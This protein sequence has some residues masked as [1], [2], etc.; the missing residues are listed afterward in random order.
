LAEAPLDRRKGH[1]L[2]LALYPDLKAWF[3]AF[4]LRGAP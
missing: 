4:G 3:A 1:R 2:L